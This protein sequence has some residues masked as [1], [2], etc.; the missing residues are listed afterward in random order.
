[1]D[2]EGPE[3]IAP[4]SGAEAE[5]RRHEVEAVHSRLEREF[6]LDRVPAFAELRCS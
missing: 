3:L 2:A 1:V 4:L 6:K 5:L